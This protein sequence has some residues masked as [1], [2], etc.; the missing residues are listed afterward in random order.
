VI[1][2][3]DINIWQLFGQSPHTVPTLKREYP[4]WHQGRQ[5]FCVWAILLDQPTVLEYLAAAQYWLSGF[6]V[7][8]YQRQAHITL[9][10]CGFWQPDPG[11]IRGEQL[12]NFPDAL[13]EQQF[14]A[15]DR[16]SLAPFQLRIGALN[17]FSSAPYLEVE[18]KQGALPALRT[19]MPGYFERI[20][21]V[22]FTPHVTVG[23]YRER[24][25]TDAV[26]S[27]INNFTF[28]ESPV[29]IDVNEI[30]LLCYSTHD[31]G[32]ELIVER[33]YKL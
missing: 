23:C 31:I 18:D 21:E 15:L 26:A 10:A 12:D 11:L 33:R 4:E 30:T 13:L 28:S 8:P 25:N 2:R 9:S 6:L 7:Q 24:F 22:S 1:Q 5:Q 29:V 14:Q 19:C 32:S 3:N 20:R 16:L 27:R 17:S